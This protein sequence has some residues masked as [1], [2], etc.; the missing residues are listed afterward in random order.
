MDAAFLG[1]IE[2]WRDALAGNI[3][4]R[5]PEL[6]NREL[7]YAVQITI[8]RI[9]F[10]RICEDRGIETLGRLQALLNGGD[11]YHRLCQQ[12][13]EADDRYNSG[14]FHFRMEKSRDD[15]GLDAITPR[16]KN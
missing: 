16:L 13:R 1:E 2:K 11:V 12:F 15:Q 3:A 7:N 4:R 5:N 9:I 6:K 10:L 14:L 8:D